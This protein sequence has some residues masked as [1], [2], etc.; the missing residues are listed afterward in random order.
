MIYMLNKEFIGAQNNNGF[1]TFGSFFKKLQHIQN[2][3]NIFSGRR[4]STKIGEMYDI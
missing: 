3:G 4:I 1:S 2:F